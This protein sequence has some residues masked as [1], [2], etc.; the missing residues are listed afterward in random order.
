[1]WP[2]L[3][4]A[5]LLPSPVAASVLV[6][7]D[8]LEVGTGPHLKRELAG[9]SVTVDAVEGRPS[10]DGLTVLRERLR[11]EHEVVVFD[12]GTNDPPAQP[13]VLA[14]SLQAARE[15]AG[16]RCMVVASIRRPPLNGVSSKGLDSA[17][18]DFVVRDSFVQ[19][20]DWRAASR[21]PGAMAPD[22]VHGTT[23]GYQLRAQLLADAIRA[24]LAT[25]S[26]QPPPSAPAPPRRP[27]ARPPRPPVEVPRVG[28]PTGVLPTLLASPVR[29][30][31]EAAGSALDALTP[32]R[33]DAV[34]GG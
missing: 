32:G 8:S 33:P 34:L 10:P 16:R 9:V 13:E 24:C 18:R 11:P 17:V 5:L 3:G 14:A 30:V 22:G 6:V 27:R 15:L 21:A 2:I 25:G 20:A 4:A 26:A 1:M 7:G 28:A 23:G 31:V 12:L 19:L 29:L